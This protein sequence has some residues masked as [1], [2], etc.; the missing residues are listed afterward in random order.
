MDPW[1]FIILYAAL[2]ALIGWGVYRT[3]YK[4]GRADAEAQAERLASI[5]PP[6]R[7]VGQ[8]TNADGPPA[9]INKP[10]WRQG[11]LRG[12]DAQPRK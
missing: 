10:R 11:M 6:T 9:R 3:G 5:E 12:G 7:A 2:L 8:P 4:R 1:L